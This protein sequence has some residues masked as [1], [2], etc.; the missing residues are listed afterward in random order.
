MTRERLEALIQAYRDGELS[1]LARRRAARLLARSEEAR[2]LRASLDLAGSL[3]REIDGAAPAPDVWDAVRLRLPALDAQRAGAQARRASPAL[4]RAGWLAAGATA[5]AAA[6]LAL[7][8]RLG[9]GGAPAPPAS[10]GALRWI[11][12]RGRP[13]MVLRD[14][15]EATIIW[16]PERS[17]ES[18]SGRMEVRDGV[19]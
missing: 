15:R 9:G 1:P 5:A 18:S 6:G 3:L 12:G 4:W 10:E 13:M 8:L 19:A 2:R 11:D 16:V 14:D 7:L 17:A